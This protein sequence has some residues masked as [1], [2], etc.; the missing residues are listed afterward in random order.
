MPSH[1]KIVIRAARAQSAQMCGKG[2]LAGIAPDGKS[3]IIIP[4]TCKSWDCPKCQPVKTAQWIEVAEAGKP[5]RFITLTCDP[6]RFEDAIDAAETMN[7]QYAKLVEKIRKKYGTFEYIKVW[8]LHKSGFPH[9]HILARG[10][11]ISQK[12][13]SETW[14]NLGIGEIVDIRKIRSKVQTTKYVM[15]YMGKT[16]GKL[17]AMW[18]NFRIITKSLG[19]LPESFKRER[20]TGTDGYE[21]RRLQ[22]PYWMVLAD[23]G[24]CF[25]TEIS[26][27]RFSWRAEVGLQNFEIPKS[28]E[29]TG[30]LAFVL[31][32]QHEIPKDED[33]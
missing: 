18:T 15:K 31:T 8:E 9:L 1:S 19:W 28:Q 22:A 24:A 14:S 29:V 17:A 7:K 5:E 26:F 3:A 2:T 33:F 4:M 12:W 30:I 16:I 11:F 13:L 25:A 32:A 21:W 27:N 6:G 20:T 23:L 10:T